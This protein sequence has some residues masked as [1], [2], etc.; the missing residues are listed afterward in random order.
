[1]TLE[2]IL[3]GLIALVV[4]YQLFNVLGRKVGFQA[5]PESKA[6]ITDTPPLRSLS[7]T[8]N[9]KPSIENLEA[10][11]SKESNFNEDIFLERCRDTYET[12][13]SAFHKGD[14]NQ[15]LNRLSPKVS[16]SFQNAITQRSEGV[17]TEINFV[18]PPKADIHEIN[19]EDKPIKIVVRFLAEIKE[20]T[21]AEQTVSSHR[22]TAELWTFEKTNQ[23]APNDWVL[24]KVKAAR[25]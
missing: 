9:E 19:I 21:F 13:L 8:L 11:K 6:D 20:I 17:K 16:E 22:R 10:L 23:D 18:E 14:L 2:L 24:I 4:L 25:A 12:V 1:M 5:D 3:F 7:E 15:V